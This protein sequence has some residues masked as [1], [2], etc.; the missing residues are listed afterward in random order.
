MPDVALTIGIVGPPNVDKSTLVTAL[1]RDQAL[2]VNYPLATI[3]PEGCT[4]PAAKSPTRQAHGYLPQW[5]DPPG[6]RVVRG[7][8]SSAFTA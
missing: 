2:A 3:A 4:V 5:A 6:H 8:R 1:T 7:H